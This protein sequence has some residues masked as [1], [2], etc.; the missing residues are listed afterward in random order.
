M[1]Q[2]IGSKLVRTQQVR[3]S[4]GFTLYTSQFRPQA[5]EM[6]NLQQ[7]GTIDQVRVVFDNQPMRVLV[8]VHGPLHTDVGH[9]T[10]P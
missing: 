4:R 7:V 1:A 10:T 5:Q 2:K 3:G 8:T 6:K 9:Q